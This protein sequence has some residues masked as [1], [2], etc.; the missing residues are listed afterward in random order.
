MANYHSTTYMEEKTGEKLTQ[1]V[2]DWT[3]P[4]LTLNQSY[5]LVDLTSE[6]KVKTTETLKRFQCNTPKLHFSKKKKLA[7]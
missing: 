2:M 6:L 5:S 1:N 3:S 4:Q 7:F